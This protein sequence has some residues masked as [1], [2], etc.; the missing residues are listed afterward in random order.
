LAQD[1]AQARGAFKAELQDQAGGGDL[2]F[3][4]CQTRDLLPLRG[5][6]K[7]ASST[8]RVMI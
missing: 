6:T 2:P 5:C 8:W 3:T 7:R 1:K 4:I